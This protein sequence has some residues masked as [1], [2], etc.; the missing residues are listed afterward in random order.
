MTTQQLFRTIFAISIISMSLNADRFQC[1]QEV[2]ISDKNSAISIAK[3]LY[4][5]SYKEDKYE[6]QYHNVYVDLKIDS[7]LCD[8][9][10]PLSVDITN[11]SSS[12]IN[13]FEITISSWL[14]KQSGKSYVVESIALKFQD[15]LETDFFI[16]PNQSFHFC[17]KAPN[18][19]WEQKEP[20]RVIPSR[21]EIEA[22]HSGIPLPRKLIKEFPV[23]E[24]GYG[25]VKRFFYQDNCYIQYTQ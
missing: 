23:N 22:M 6:K 16:K 10:H 25:I 3:A 15:S 9:D 5:D 18:K 24:L 1:Y 17:S 13:A 2:K 7:K 4:D 14:T 19:L 8:K 20:L 21:E 11:K 12:S